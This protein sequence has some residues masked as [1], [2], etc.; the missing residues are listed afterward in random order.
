MK[1]KDYFYNDHND[2]EQTNNG[3]TKT[4]VAVLGGTGVV[5]QV[6]VAMLA[7]HPW[8]ELAMIVG[9]DSRAGKYYGD[10]VHWQLPFPLPQA[11]VESRCEALSLDE[12]NS[13]IRKI[14]DR[15]IRIVFSALP[16]DVAA[17]VE[18]VL[19]DNGCWVFSNASALRYEPDV[20]IL[21][22]DVN[23]QAVHL[24]EQ[25]GFPARGFVIT[26]ANCSTTGLASALA[27]LA[28]FPI[29]EITVSTY[30]SISGA[31]YPGLSALDIMGNVIPFIQKEEEKMIIELKKIMG[32]KAPLYPHCVR[33]P[34]PFGHLETVWLTFAR[35]VE[36]EEV[37]E[38][39]NHYQMPG[40]PLP[41]VPRQPVVYQA[42]VDFPQPRT[43]FWGQPAGMQT[44]T[45][46]LKKVNNKI[47]FALLSNNLVKGAAGGSI[48]NAELFL[49]I[50]EGQYGG[51]Q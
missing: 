9:S 38:A 51:Q 12:I 1:N 18:P 36:T 10:E 42:G 41:S 27:P 6:F 21:I 47:G 35:P 32:L 17:T 23:P 30:Q 49:D 31:G 5:G 50:Y 20:P 40:N 43:S 16:T 4:R 14:K 34:V 25:Q 3:R 48:A 26:N 13:N 11:V 33:V 45:G 8:F 22:P 7:N 29:E 46:R 39:W 2:K 28:G 24:I 37:Q 44:F 19:R 15:D